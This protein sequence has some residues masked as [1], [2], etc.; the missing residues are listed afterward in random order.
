M[1]NFICFGLT[2]AITLTIA[3]MLLAQ[4]GPPP[5]LGGPGEM[6]VSGLMLVTVPEVRQELG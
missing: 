2:V 5:G 3:T 4:F 1:K 6:P